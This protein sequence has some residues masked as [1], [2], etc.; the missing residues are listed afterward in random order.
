MTSSVMDAPVAF[1]IFNRADT[2]AR[3]FAE[4]SK[5]KPSKLFVIADGPR[6]ARPG[7]AEKCAAVRAMIDKVDWE[8]EVLKNY[9]DVNLGCGARV[10]SG[11]SWVFEH[12]DRAIILED[13]CVPHRSFFRF[14]GELLE[15]FLVDERV[16]M[17]NGHNPFFQVQNRSYSY[18]FSRLGIAWGWATWAQSLEAPR[19]ENRAM[20]A[21]SGYALVVGYL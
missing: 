14:C 19:Y 18:T 9:S 7:E 5:A 10:A 4:I 1:I 2:A 8:C 3:V 17:I 15:E 16:M 13:D 11:I 12:V 20:A 6:P 21:T